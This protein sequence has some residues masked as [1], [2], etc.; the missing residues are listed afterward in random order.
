MEVF[1][2]ASA[3]PWTRLVGLPSG[4]QDKAV[5]SPDER[6]MAT[7][8]P[9]LYRTGDRAD[10]WQTLW[11][12]EPALLPRS[13]DDY[14]FDQWGQEV[15]FSPDLTML[16]VSRCRKWT[17]QARL[18]AVADGAELADL[19]ALTAPHPSFSPEGH[20]LVAGATLLHLPSGTVRSL[21]TTG[22]TAV[23]IFAPNGDIIAGSSD[24]TLRRYCR[25]P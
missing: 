18:F 21:D 20:W 24:Q 22:T 11:S 17:C 2:T 25:S 13:F 9:A 10:D 7:S 15:R 19:P 3:M 8:V 14:T 23:A 1:P 6:W 5:F 4:C 16:L 12:K